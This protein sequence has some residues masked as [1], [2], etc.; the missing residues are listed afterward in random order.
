MLATYAPI[1]PWALRR[2][3]PIWGARAAADGESELADSGVHLWL[4]LC[5]VGTQVM[6][7]THSRSAPAASN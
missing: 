3:C 5:I 7:A 1:R 4:S 2:P 6:S